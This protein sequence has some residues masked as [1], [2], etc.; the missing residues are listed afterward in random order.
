MISQALD[1]EIHVQKYSKFGLGF[2]KKFLIERGACPVF[3]VAN[4]SPVPVKEVFAPGDFKEK[5][6]APRNKG[7]VDRALFFD[8]SVRALLDVYAALDSMC[9]KSRR[10]VKSTDELASQF[11]ERFGLLF[12]L[13]QEQLV[14]VESVLRDNDK[15]AKT[16]QMFSNFLL[17]YVF[18]FTKSFD[19]HRSIDEEANYYMEREWR[20][21]NHVNFTLEE[22][23]HVF[24]PAKF[25]KRFRNEIPEYFGQISFIE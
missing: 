3:Y 23:A 5:I 11:K 7:F 12:N 18:S 2:K 1:F 22:V 25:A 21:G 17:N 15:A 4:E 13:T 10:F 8:T 24:F 20:I 6:D 14:A 16:L 19:A 9:D